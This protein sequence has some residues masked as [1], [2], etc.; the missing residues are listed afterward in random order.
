[1]KKSPNESYDLLYESLLQLKDAEECRRF[2]E[3]LCTVNE[4]KAMTQRIEVA[5]YLREGMIYQDILKRT[6]ASSATISRV[7]RCLQYG[8]EGYQTV[9]PRVDL[10]WE[11]EK[12]EAP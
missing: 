8:A 10:F 1:M 9:L 7:N 2:M 12:K 5:M 4:L 3:D 6:G 11:K